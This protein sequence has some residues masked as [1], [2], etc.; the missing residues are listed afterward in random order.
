VE[1]LVAGRKGELATAIG[2][3]EGSVFEFHLDDLLSFLVPVGA[4]IE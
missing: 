3:N 2:A 4:V 1:L